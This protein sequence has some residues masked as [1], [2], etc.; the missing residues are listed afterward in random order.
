MKYGILIACLLCSPLA[1]GQNK[2]WTHER[3]LRTTYLS[4]ESAYDGYTTQYLEARGWHELNPI[5]R[6]LVDRGWGG[7]VAACALGVGAVVG[8]E[9]AVHRFHHDKIAN[10]IGRVAS[11][12]ESLNIARQTY[13]VEMSNRW[14]PAL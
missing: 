1:R 2:F 14:S 9:Y 12:G 10:W 11:A 6:P 13:E 3:V 5:A 8:L 7:Q 4:G